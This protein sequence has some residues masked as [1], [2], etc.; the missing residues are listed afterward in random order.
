MNNYFENSP[1][2]ELQTVEYHKHILDFCSFVCMLYNKK[3]NFPSI[4]VMV[5]ENEKL[6]RIYMDLCNFDCE[7]EALM[8]FLKIDETIVKSKFVKRIIKNI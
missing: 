8:E 5:I 6:K 4:F 3:M 1:L 7:R 2:E